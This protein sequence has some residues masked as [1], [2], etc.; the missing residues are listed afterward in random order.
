MVKGKD[1]RRAGGVPGMASRVA[2][3]AQ[4]DQSVCHHFL[5]V[6]AIAGT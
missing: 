1:E 3:A 4:R 6:V 2:G 5:G